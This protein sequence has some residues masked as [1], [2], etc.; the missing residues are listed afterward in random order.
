MAHKQ[1]VLTKF[2]KPIAQKEKEM[3]LRETTLQ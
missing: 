1:V 3:W 2:V